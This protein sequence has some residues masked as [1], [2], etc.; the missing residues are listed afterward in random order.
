MCNVHGWMAAWVGVV[1]HPYYAVT[2]ETGAF[3]LK[4]VPPGTY[5]IE[6]WHEKFGVQTATVTVAPSQQ[7]TTT[8]TFTAKGAN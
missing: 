1:A 5:T 6:A 8:F 4:G 2:D 3:E 7:Q